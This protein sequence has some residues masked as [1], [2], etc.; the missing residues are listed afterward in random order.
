VA[1]NFARTIL[2]KFAA[3][4]MVYVNVTAVVLSQP[5]EL[6]GARRHFVHS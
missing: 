3:T 4:A 5:D 6:D 1:C 2:Q